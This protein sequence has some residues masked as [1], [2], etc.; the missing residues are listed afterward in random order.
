LHHASPKWY[1]D[2]STYC[3]RSRGCNKYRDYFWVRA[4]TI[5]TIKADYRRI[6]SKL[7]LVDINET[8]DDIIHD[9]LVRELNKQDH[10]LMIFDNLKDIGFVEGKLPRPDG[11]RHLILTMLDPDPV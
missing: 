3:G 9:Q 11:V 1:L 8:Q 10:W 7:A 4:D 2:S 6:A 5:E